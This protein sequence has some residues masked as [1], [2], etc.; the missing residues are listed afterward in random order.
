MQETL[1]MVVACISWQGSWPPGCFDP[2]PI[3][4]YYNMQFWFLFKSDTGI[5]NYGSNHQ[6]LYVSY[7]IAND[8]VNTVWKVL[9]LSKLIF[10]EVSDSSNATKIFWIWSLVLIFV[11]LWCTEI[12]SGLLLIFVVLT[13]VKIP[14][15]VFQFYYSSTFSLKFYCAFSRHC[16]AF[17]SRSF[18]LVDAFGD[19][20]VALRS[21]PLIQIFA[22]WP[23]LTVLE[24]SRL[25]IIHILI[26]FQT[27]FSF[28][29]NYN[30]NVELW[31]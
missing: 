14:I 26:R 3:F 11:F 24:H 23:F 9:F 30:W 27:R 10:P 4:K 12:E 19:V 2:K 29:V 31:F 18:V 22:F 25:M 13:I 7:W 5:I 8:S 20:L 16:V 21:Y 1:T 15:V 17:V 28:A 6:D